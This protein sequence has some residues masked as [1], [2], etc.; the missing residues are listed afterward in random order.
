MNF[1]MVLK[2]LF[3]KEKQR[4]PLGQHIRSVFRVLNLVNKMFKHLVLYMI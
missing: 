3:L 2:N 1:L 4:T